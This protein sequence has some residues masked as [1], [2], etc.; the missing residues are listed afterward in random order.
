MAKE[1]FL[2]WNCYGGYCKRGDDGETYEYL[3]DLKSRTIIKGMTTSVK[4]FHATLQLSGLMRFTYNTYVVYSMSK[5]QASAIFPELD[6][7]KADNLQF[8]MT[9]EELTRLAKK[10]NVSTISGEW[11]FKSTT[12]H[13]L[14]T[15]KD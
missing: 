2:T 4:N 9:G 5:E 8:L 6:L 3:D 1:K 13:H 10:T 14:L 7:T 15:L 11:T 12:S